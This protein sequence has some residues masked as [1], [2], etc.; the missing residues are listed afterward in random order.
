MAIFQLS[1]DIYTTQKLG[2]LSLLTTYHFNEDAVKLT[3]KIQN[4]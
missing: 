1:T 2:A 3:F 4:H